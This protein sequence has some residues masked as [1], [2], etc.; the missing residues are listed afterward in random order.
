MAHGRVNYAL[1]RCYNVRCG[2]AHGAFQ[3]LLL[4]HQLANIVAV[5]L[6]LLGEE[7]TAF[8]IHF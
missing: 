2:L 1:T 8:L 7:L 6:C 3:V 4:V 5:A